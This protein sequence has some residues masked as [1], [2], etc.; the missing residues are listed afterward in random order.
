MFNR[1]RGMPANWEASQNTKED[2]GPITNYTASILAKP[3]DID[4]VSSFHPDF[5]QGLVNYQVE[6]Y[7]RVLDKFLSRPDQELF[8]QKQ[9]AL[10]AIVSGP[11][12]IEAFTNSAPNNALHVYLPKLRDADKEM[13][14]FFND[15]GFNT[16]ARQTVSVP[17]RADSSTGHIAFQTLQ[18]PRTTNDGAYVADVHRL[19]NDEGHVVEIVSARSHPLEI[20]LNS[21]STM[22]MTFITATEMFMLYPQLTLLDNSTLDTTRKPGANIKVPSAYLGFDN[23]TVNPVLTMY[24][25]L[26]VTNDLTVLPRRVGDDLC[27]VVPL[28]PLAVPDLLMAGHTSLF[29]S[30]SWQLLLP[31]DKSHRICSDFLAARR[32]RLPY[33]LAPSVKMEISRSLL[34]S[35]DQPRHGTVDSIL[36]SQRERDHETIEELSKIYQKVFAADSPWKKVAAAMYKGA[37][38]SRCDMNTPPNL[39]PTAAVTSFAFETLLKMPAVK[40]DKARIQLRLMSIPTDNPNDI[41]RI[42]VL[43]IVTMSPH[44]ANLKDNQLVNGDVEQLQRL[45]LQIHLHTDPTLP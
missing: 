16:A 17:Q 24:D 2:E 34:K 30:H 37:I 9:L 31:S 39:L 38:D 41:P 15:K 19:I 25:L 12:A 3:L 11:T 45:G 6:K 5:K 21:T 35:W 29:R 4:T 22:M 14:R 33:I 7:R 42:G 8:R 40:D 44:R 36:I 32:L 18:P 27:V 1:N 10:G 13:V 20:T 28:P 26:D 43:L 23:L